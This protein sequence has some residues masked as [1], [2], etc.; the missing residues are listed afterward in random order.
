VVI[1]GLKAVVA[2]LELANARVQLRK[3]LLHALLQ[4]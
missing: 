2:L 4:I 1:L 3:P